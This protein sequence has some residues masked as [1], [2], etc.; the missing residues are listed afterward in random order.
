MSQFFRLEHSHKKYHEWLWLQRST[1]SQTT[2]VILTST[3]R[4]VY[5]FY[6]KCA[7]QHWL[8][9]FWRWATLIGSFEFNITQLVKTLL[10]AFDY[11]Q[12]Y[13]KWY[14]KCE[15]WKCSVCSKQCKN[16]WI[17]YQFNCKHLAIVSNAEVDLGL[18]QHPRWSILW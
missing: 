11:N 6:H 2:K 16:C 14:G 5:H 9:N 4:V 17:C 15:M 8:A 13:L 12:L 3:E 18:L 1:L 10:A 7:T